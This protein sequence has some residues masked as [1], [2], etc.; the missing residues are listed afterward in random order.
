MDVTA[1][2]LYLEQEFG[3]MQMP[4]LI[5]LNQEVLTRQKER[6]TFH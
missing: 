2:Y 1:R 6:I 4:I 5:L 3:Y